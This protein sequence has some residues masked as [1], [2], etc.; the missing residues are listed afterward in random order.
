MA[1]D[2]SEESRPTGGKLDLCR[3]WNSGSKPVWDPPALLALG[4]EVGMGFSTLGMGFFQHR[5]GI[6]LAWKQDFSS[7]EMGLFQPGNGIF[8][9]LGMGFF[10]PRNGTFPALEQGFSISGMNGIFS[11]SGMGFFQF[12]NGTSPT[13]T[14]DFSGL[15]MGFF[16]PRMELFQL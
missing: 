14:W 9:T 16:Q 12:G 13:Q 8:S 7:P 11:S 1:G 3:G 10:Q 4:N 15:G 5:N 6:F 2:V